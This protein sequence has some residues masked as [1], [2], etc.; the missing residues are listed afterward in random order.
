M[1]PTKFAELV[2]GQIVSKG[3]DIDLKTAALE[4][5]RRFGKHGHH[6]HFEWMGVP[7]I[8]TPQDLIQMQQLIFK[9]K[10]DLIVE[11]GVARGGSVI[12]YAS[13]LQLLAY[14]NEI[15]QDYNVVGIDIDIR[16]YTRQV[17]NNHPLRSRIH[18]VDGSSISPD[19]VRQVKDISSNFSRVLLCLDSDHTREHV[20]DELRLLSPIVTVGSYCVVFDTLVEFLP[21]E[22]YGDRR[23][24]PG[25]SPH[26]AVSEFLA[27]NSE[28]FIIDQDIDHKLVVSAAINGFLKRIK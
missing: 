11:T 2:R 16:E 5:H 28:S 15:R 26:N 18:L 23:W 12:F 14:S 13:M 4:V 21:S 20:L 19:V 24:G 25:N 8:Q 6:H 7:V 27:D 3:S 1:D 22:D 9:V 17:L 10:P